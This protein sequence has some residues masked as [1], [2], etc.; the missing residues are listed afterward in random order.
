VSAALVL[1]RDDGPLARAIAAATGPLAGLPQAATVLLAAAPMFVLMA[2]KGDD[3]STSAVAVVLAWLV[4]VAGTSAGRAPGGRLKW[5]VSPVLRLAEY[6]GLLWIGAL[7]GRTS[8]PAAFALI[9]VLAFRHYDLVYRLRHQGVAPPKWVGDLAC[10]WDGRLVLGYIL[11]VADALPAG[12]YIAA[13]LFATVF[14]G[15]SVAGWRRFGRV[16]HPVT[17]EDEEDEGQ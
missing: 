9:C 4:L 1:Y 7:G 12:L 14:A 5:A 15:E 17:Y 8:Q 2:V 13:G 6:S 16:D 10:G 11:L 3:A